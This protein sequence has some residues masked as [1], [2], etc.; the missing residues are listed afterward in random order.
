MNETFIQ[1]PFSNDHSSR[2]Y[3]TGDLARE[4]PDGKIQFLGRN[5]NQ[6]KIRGYRIE[7]G[8]IEAVLTKY[9]I[10]TEC[11]V[12]A[13][14][15]LKDEMRKTGIGIGRPGKELVAYI[16]SDEEQLKVSELRNF[17]KQ[18]LPEYMIPSSFVVLE[19]L[20]L[21]LNG[22]VD[23]NR[24]PP[25]SGTR[26]PFAKEFAA[27]RTE[28]EELIAQTWQDVLR[29]ENIGIQ[30]N[31]FEL[32]GYSLLA[33]Q[34]VARLQEAFNKDVPLRVLF[35]APTIG[36]LAQ[37]LERIIR[38]GHAAELPRI[39]PV[40]RDVPLPL[41]MNQEQLWNLH[42][43]IP[44]THLFNMPYAYR[45]SGELNVEALE[46]ALKEII[47]RHEALRTV[48][49]KIS[50]RPV[51]ITNDGADFRLAVED[52]RAEALTDIAQQSA[53]LIVE[54]RERQF[55]LMVGPL[56]RIKLIRLT[57]NESVLL[58][59]MHHIISDHGS[60]R[61]FGDELIKIYEAYSEGRSSPFA[62]LSIQFADYAAW[63]THLLESGLMDGQREYW[64]QQL[65]GFLPKLEFRQSSTRNNELSFYTSRKQIEIDEWLFTSVKSLAARKNCTM[66]M[67][68]LA[69]LNLVLYDLT[70]QDDIR[71]GT[72]VANRR[73]KNSDPVIGHFLNTIIIRTKVDPHY[74]KLLTKIREITLAAHAHQELPFEQLARDLKKERNIERASLFQV[75]LSYQKSSFE[76]AKAAGV[77]FA[78]LGW[79]LPVQD[80]EMMLTACDVIANVRETST[81][82]TVS[83]NY[84]TDSVDS[85]VVVSML[86]CFATV[87]KRM[88][89]DT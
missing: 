2:L 73:W 75:L 30:D 24:L 66:Y 32:G 45:L 79:Q 18:K 23:R 88:T 31:F 42:Q 55:D 47:R 20:P 35:D 36:E 68:V 70:G 59:T 69:A 37:E 40:P 8:E 38:D 39:L 57:N 58:C 71:I 64:I 50:G 7:L 74:G 63:E 87:L 15:D 6:V 49:A 14:S 54:E 21:T 27:V 13:S 5:D 77:E 28:I 89:V 9:P 82:L 81:K 72:L 25:P 80:S 3:R 16:V 46:R 33:T 86:E 29:I 78:Q 17:L 11:V 52:L 19:V 67:V 10:V 84:K 48:F 4:L 22:K 34:I 41:S 26:P 61:V 56:F 44:D 85:N 12:V 60:M 62:D 65:A 51:Q 43:A 53:A 1:N 83:V 76:S